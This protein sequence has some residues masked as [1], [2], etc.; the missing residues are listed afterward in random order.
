MELLAGFTVV[1]IRSGSCSESLA[2]S[3]IKARIL[4]HGRSCR[5]SR[6]YESGTSAEPLPLQTV[7]SSG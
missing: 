5:R 7:D 4:G 3:F 6:L 1:P 2:A